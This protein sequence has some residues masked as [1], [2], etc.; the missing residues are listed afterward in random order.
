[1]KNQRITT[2]D[3]QV[4]PG[5][6]K[7]YNVTIIDMQSSETI[8]K[9]I[10][11]DNKKAAICQVLNNIYNENWVTDLYNESTSWFDYEQKLLDVDINASVE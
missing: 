10:V 6:R 7:E 5:A 9:K 8:I 11:A 1:M 4:A 2:S 3:I